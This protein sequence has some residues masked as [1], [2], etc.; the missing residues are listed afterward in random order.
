[1]ENS[2]PGAEGNHHQFVTLLVAAGA[3]IEPDWLVG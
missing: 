2:E 3:K 1:M